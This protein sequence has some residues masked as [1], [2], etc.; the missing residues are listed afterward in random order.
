M[1]CRK[2]F[3]KRNFGLVTFH[4]NVVRLTNVLK[5][6]YERRL[7]Q[8]TWY[9]VREAFDFSIRRG[10]LYKTTNEHFESYKCKEQ[11]ICN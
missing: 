7:T 2:T 11:F 3:Q 6:Q 5:N 9:S 1:K 8:W 10:R 4:K